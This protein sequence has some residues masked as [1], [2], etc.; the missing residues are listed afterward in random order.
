MY[1]SGEDE[2]IWTQPE[3]VSHNCS[4]FFHQPRSLKNHCGCIHEED[5]ISARAATH[6]QRGKPHSPDSDTN[7][8]LSFICMICAYGSKA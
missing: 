1:A 3:A 2:A 4:T 7:A 6:F 5:T 8:F